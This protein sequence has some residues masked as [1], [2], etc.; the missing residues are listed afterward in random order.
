MDVR[1]GVLNN[2][3]WKH[4]YE[5]KKAQLD[6]TLAGKNKDKDKQLYLIME[7]PDMDDLEGDD[8]N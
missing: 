7:S 5:V 6:E 4:D 3:I 1:I 8:D 2:I